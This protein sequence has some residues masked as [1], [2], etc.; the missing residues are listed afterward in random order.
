MAVINQDPSTGVFLIRFRFNGRRVNRSLKTNQRRSPSPFSTGPKKPCGSST[1]G[2]SKCL[3]MLTRQLSFF[4]LER[5]R[6]TDFLRIL[7]SSKLARTISTEGLQ[8]YVKRRLK[9]R[10]GTR[11]ISPE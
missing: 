6:I 3:Q 8:R 1:K 4:A 2:D 7:P 10:C 9:E 5:T 11:Q